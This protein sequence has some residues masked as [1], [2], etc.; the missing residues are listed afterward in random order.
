ME[1]AG[2]RSNGFEVALEVL[3]RR[4]W[5]AILTFG[6][7]FAAVV[8]I[9]MFLPNV[10]RASATLII[11]RQQIPEEFVKSTVTSAVE[12]RLQTISQEILSRSRLESLINRFGLY[13]HLRE[14]VPLE[15]VVERVRQDI[16]ARAEAG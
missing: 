12:T 7:M 8:S 1:D 6:G 5:L 14:Q 16:R 13:T 3:S 4:K 2:R 11:D 9:V 15:A 10:Y